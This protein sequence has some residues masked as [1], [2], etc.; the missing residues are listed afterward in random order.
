[1][2][3]ADHARLY[4]LVG[5]RISLA[6]SA[7]GL[8]QAKLAKLLQMSRVSVVNIEAGRQ[9]APFHV[10]WDI[11]CALGIAVD[12]LIPGLSE[13]TDGVPELELDAPT[14]RQIREAAMNDPATRRQLTE[15]IQRAKSKIERPSASSSTSKA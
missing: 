13:L 15:F 6:R 3:K 4:E 2:R 14:V 12:Q 9:R 8:S 7:S 11:A 1:V 10:L 5:Q